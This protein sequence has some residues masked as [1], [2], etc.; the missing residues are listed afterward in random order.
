MNASQSHTRS[1]TDPQALEARLALRLVGHLNAQAD[2]LPSDVRERLRFAREQALVRARE[3]RG[4]AVTGPV[5][6]SRSGTLLLGSLVPWLQRAAS[7]LPLLLLL[8]GLLVIQ[9]WASRERV[10][11]AAEIDSQLLAD[12]L[13]PTAYGDPGFAEFLRSPPQP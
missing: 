3:A 2:R 1:H 4:A 11:A 6:V 10:L 13:P 9:Q 12:T 8:G 5:G 7:V